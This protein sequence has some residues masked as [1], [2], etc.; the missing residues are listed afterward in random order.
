MDGWMDCSD[1]YF[2]YGDQQKRLEIMKDPR[3]GAFGVLSVL[4]LLSWRFLLIYETV[5]ADPQFAVVLFFFIPFI[6]RTGM[7]SLLIEAPLAREE[8]MAYAMKK[9]LSTKGFGVFGFY[10]L[11]A[12]IA[13]WR[14]GSLLLFIELLLFAV[15]G[16]SISRL[17]FVHQFGGIT[18]DTLGAFSEGMETWLWFAGWLLLSFATV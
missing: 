12:G 15:V 7:G 14:S 18:G 10:F 16:Y 17:F 6:A 11:V 9:N 3:T 4:F 2:S 1:A 5:K 8:G 13:A